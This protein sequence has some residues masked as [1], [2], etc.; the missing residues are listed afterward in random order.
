MAKVDMKGFRQ[1]KVDKQESTKTTKDAR[2]AEE[3]I[4]ASPLL[5][6]K[7]KTSAFLGATQAERKSI[8]LPISGAQIT[9]K[10]VLIDPEDCV[11]HP[12]NRRNQ[13]LL[14]LENPR[15]AQ[16]KEAIQ[17]EG[18]R[19]PALARMI[20]DNGTQRLEIID[21]SRRRF[22]VEK[23]R[24]GSPDIKLK[25]WLAQTMSDADADYL[26]R[27][28]N[29]NRDDI[30]AWETAQ[31]LQRISQENPSWSHEVIGA[32]EGMSRQSVSNYLMLSE[33]PLPLVALL[34]SPNVMNVKSGV[35]LTKNCR[36]LSDQ[37]I[38]RRIEALASD[39]PFSEFTTLLK[40][41]RAQATTPKKPKPLSI[42]RRI[43]IDHAGKRR[44]VIG[45]NRTKTGQYKIDVFDVS[46][47]ELSLIE[48]ALRKVLA[49]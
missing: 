29:E 34:E 46:D 15:V 45:K 20:D 43:E 17:G 35:L 41:F 7:G 26:T 5:S 27:A 39:A 33:V 1:S 36:G 23:I 3:K 38:S 32:Q 22:V 28:E 47:E 21:G 14:R 42:N 16:L 44:A 6:A 2:R 49:S 13:A 18:Q 48:D 30:S 19:D 10:S 12:N 40:A 11:I 8:T 37:E 31:Y 25:V 24:E 4:T 9:L